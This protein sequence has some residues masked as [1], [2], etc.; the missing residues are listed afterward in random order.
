MPQR[1]GESITQWR[2]RALAEL[3]E[4]S[5][6]FERSRL[7]PVSVRQV[8]SGDVFGDRDD[9]KSVLRRL[10]L[11]TKDLLAAFNESSGVSRD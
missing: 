2:S 9:R 5:A 10:E 7:K 6:E 3:H 4:A 8:F 1:A 11:T